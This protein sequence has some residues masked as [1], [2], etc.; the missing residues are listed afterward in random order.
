MVLPTSSP[1]RVGFL[2]GLCCPDQKSKS[3]QFPGPW[4]QMTSALHVIAYI[5]NVH[6]WVLFL[7]FCEWVF[8]NIGIISELQPNMTFH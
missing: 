4:L 3:P 1:R 8:G 5:L 6:L 2:V 7:S